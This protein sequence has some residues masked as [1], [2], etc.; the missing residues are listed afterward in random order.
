MYYIITLK[1][2]KKMN[3]IKKNSFL[4]G[5]CVLVQREW[6]EFGHKFADRCGNGVC[7]PDSNERCPV[8][9]QWLDCVHQL[10]KQFPS[11]FQFNEAVLVS[12]IIFSIL[13]FIAYTLKMLNLDLGLI[14]C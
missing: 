12:R 6:L 11:A 1:D 4:Q 8:F 3:L 7:S 14:R 10:L 13:D 2:L 5:F 9:L